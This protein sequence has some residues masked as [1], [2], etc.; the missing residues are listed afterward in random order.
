MAINRLYL[1]T[2]GL[3]VG[4]GQLVAI[5]N[6]ISIANNLFVGGNLTS[7]GLS[8]YTVS[9][10]YSA[11]STVYNANGYIV[12]FNQNGIVTTNVVYN[13]NGSPTSWTEV[14][15]ISAPGSNI[16][17]NYVASYDNGG[18]IINIARTYVSGP[19][20]FSG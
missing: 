7:P 9:S 10:A 16:V 5:G 8:K 4:N 17:Y 15:T 2:D 20:G 13:G 3:S 18:Y 1:D 19:V 14:D 6:N 11:N 12:T